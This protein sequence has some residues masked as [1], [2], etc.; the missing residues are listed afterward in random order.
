VDSGPPSTPYRVIHGALA[1]L[2]TPGR[3]I[4]LIDVTG[5]PDAPV[6]RF[7]VE[8]AL[9]PEE[10]AERSLEP[11]PDRIDGVARKI[12]VGRYRLQRFGPPRSANQR[13][14]DPLVGGVSI[15]R[16]NQVSA[17]TLGGLVHDSASGDPL[18]LSNFHVLVAR[19]GVRPGTQQIVQPGRLDGGGLGDAVGSYLRHGM[20]DHLDAAIASVD[21]SRRLVAQQYGIGAY[22]GRTEPFLGQHVVKQGRSTQRTQGVVT[23]INGQAVFNYGSV[24]WRIREI[25]SIDP[26]PGSPIVSGPGDSGSFWLDAQTHTAVALHFAG[27]DQPERALAIDL[28]PVCEALAVDVPA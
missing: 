7:H 22:R 6:V 21:G 4:N 25:V 20:D 27:S 10:L 11:L 12:V 5:T 3:E 9:V 18:L 1:Y 19:W 24:R 17:G 15:S 14:V 2:R 8:R 26:V 28:G 16:S 23:G 13:R